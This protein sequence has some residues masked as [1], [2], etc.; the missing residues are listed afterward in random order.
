[1]QNVIYYYYHKIAT[2][3]GNGSTDLTFNTI[4]I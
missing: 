3:V 2:R 1:M 4:H